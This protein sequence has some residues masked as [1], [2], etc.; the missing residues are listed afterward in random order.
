MISGDNIRD[1]HSRMKRADVR[2][3]ETAF[4]E[5]GTGA[6]VVLLH[7]Y[8]FNSSMWIEQVESLRARVRVLTPD[9]RGLGQSTLSSG[10]VT[11]EEMA[12]DTVALMDKL[13][14]ERAVV[15][16]LSMGGY[17]TLAFY[18]LFPERVRALIL[19]DTRAQADTE[20]GRR[21]REE[22]ALKA[23]SEGMNPIAEAMLPKLLSQATLSEQPEIAAR[24]REM[25][26]ATNPAGAAAAQRAMAGRQDHTDFISQIL[27]PTLIIVGSEDPITPVK[28]SELMHER[29]RGSRLHVI[30]GAAHVSNIERP[31][32]FNSALE[33][34]LDSLQP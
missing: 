13:G 7:G 16:G 2:G 28:D 25:M 30:D 21:T 34:F 23:L 6:P 1:Y 33:E 31:V 12:K 26:T 29:V 14:I 11:M 24:V 32:E 17:V 22:Q 27:V 15:G 20:E 3:I 18:R 4:Q 19:A 9:L 8:P 5:A 10:P